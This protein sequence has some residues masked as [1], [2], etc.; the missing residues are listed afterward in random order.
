MAPSVVATMPRARGALGQRCAR[1][2]VQE[3]CPLMPVRRRTTSLAATRRPP[4]DLMAPM[5]ISSWRRADWILIGV[6]LVSPRAT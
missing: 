4:T 6:M 2:N 1:S 5:R 3:D